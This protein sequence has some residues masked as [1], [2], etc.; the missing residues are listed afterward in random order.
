VLNNF[1]VRL[2]GHDPQ[3]IRGEGRE[4]VQP[5]A[6]AGATILLAAFVTVANWAIAGYSLADGGNSQ[7]RW[8]GAILG[9]TLGFSVVLVID[10]AGVYQMDTQAGHPLRKSAVLIVRMF[11]VLLVSAVTTAAVAPWLMASELKDYVL[12]MRESADAERAHML[13]ERF[14]LEALR[15]AA[16]RIDADVDSARKAGFTIPPDIKARLER[17]QTCWQDFIKR[18]IQLLRE[19]YSDGYVRE[20]L[21]GYAMRCDA[22]FD[23]ARRDLDTYVKRNRADLADAERRQ[24]TAQTALRQ[25][26][27]DINRRLIEAGAIEEEAITAQ[28]AM[29]L[30]GLLESNHGARKKWYGVC[31]FI[32]CLELLPLTLKL[33][34]DKSISGLRIIA[35]REIASDACERRRELVREDRIRERVLRAAMDAAMNEAFA[36]PE[37]QQHMSKLFQS[38]VEALIPIEIAKRLIAEI[39]TGAQNV[40]A[41]TRRRPSCAHAIAEAWSHAMAEVTER[42]L[43]SRYAQ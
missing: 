13:N 40:E 2:S 19:G 3:A 8:I 10:R 12:H 15:A 29:V 7:H 5:I 17:G 1:L 33:L 42:L 28:S 34:S 38:K 26:E 16:R 22:D 31:A 9:A 18:K 24:S 6:M 36:S 23:S 27:I 21:D 32:V 39:E 41:A 20:L 37:V 30:D 25:A 11:V 43:S 14:S 35:D 4:A